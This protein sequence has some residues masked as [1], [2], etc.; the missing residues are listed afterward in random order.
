MINPKNNY[1]ILANFK[2]GVYIF[3]IYNNIFL[4]TIKKHLYFYKFIPF[5]ENVQLICKIND[6]KFE[7]YESFIFN[8]EICFLAT[9]KY[10]LFYNWKKNNII[11]KINY[12]F[13]NNTQVILVNKIYYTG[14][15]NESLKTFFMYNLLTNKLFKYTAKLKKEFFDEKIKNNLFFNIDKKNSY[16]I[17][18][19]Y[20]NYFLI[21][22]DYYYYLFQTSFNGLKVLMENNYYNGDKQNIIVDYKNK[23]KKLFDN[24]DNKNKINESKNKIQFLFG[25]NN[26]QEKA[27]FNESINS[28][29][30]EILIDIS[31]GKDKN[32]QDN[33]AQH[34]FG[35]DEFKKT[36]EKST[37]LFGNNNN[38]SLFGNNNNSSL[39]GNNN[40]TSLFGKNNTSLF[41][42][43][44][45]PFP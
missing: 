26:N 24:F 27:L 22:S 38:R 18:N 14:I 44:N 36:F 25:N 8:H 34:L 45:N 13:N 6:F 42:N 7:I 33:N 19:I 2:N 5:L 32:V 11:R 4:I 21:W 43:N 35:D 29:N 15:I 41:E 23:K 28:L 9:D 16:R 1:K 31:S 3:P 10:L 37:S 17:I 12:L 40:N 20:N 39:F 30:N